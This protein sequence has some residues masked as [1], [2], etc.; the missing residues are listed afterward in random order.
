ME[1]VEIERALK[2]GSVNPRDL[3]MR[4]GREIVEQFHGA[5]AAE[6]AEAEFIKVFQQHDLPTDM[7]TF[8]MQKAKRGD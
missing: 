8:T 3:K 4:L 5:D 2:S 7:P 6:N 1:L